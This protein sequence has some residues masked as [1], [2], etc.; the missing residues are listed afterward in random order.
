MKRTVYI[1]SI[2]KLE[3]DEP[4]LSKLQVSVLGISQHDYKVDAKVFEEDE[5]NPDYPAEAV[6]IDFLKGNVAELKEEV[7]RLEGHMEIAVFMLQRLTKRLKGA[8]YGTN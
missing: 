5:W 7:R 4:D 1:K 6:H 8:Q 3:T 2:I